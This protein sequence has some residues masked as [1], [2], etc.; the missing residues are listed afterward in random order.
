VSQKEEQK[1]KLRGK[2]LSK[3]YQK[4]PRTERNESPT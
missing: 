4:C 2:K 1:G 3:K